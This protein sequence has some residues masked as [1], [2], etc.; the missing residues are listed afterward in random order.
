MIG[1]KSRNHL[2]AVVVVAVVALAS[3]TGRATAA[4][5]LFYEPT[6]GCSNHTRVLEMTGT[7][8]AQ[9]GFTTQLM[10]AQFAFRNLDTGGQWLYSP[11]SN[12]KNTYRDFGGGIAVSV[13][14]DATLSYTVSPGHYEVFVRYTWW[15]GARWTDMTGWVRSNSYGYDEWLNEGSEYPGVNFP[16]V[17][18][19][20]C[21]VGL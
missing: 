21:P 3:L 18:G 5:G 13:P 12:F 6:V 8:N 2:I 17:L 15:N 16:T 9:D 7:A 20:S 1:R 19:S 11:W 14:G 4:P 10:S